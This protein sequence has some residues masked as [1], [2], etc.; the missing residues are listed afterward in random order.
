M[1]VFEFAKKLMKN[2]EFLAG[3]I[4]K[5]ERKMLD[6]VGFEYTMKNG[7]IHHVGDDATE[8]YNAMATLVKLQKKYS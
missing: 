6:A 8:F 7:T 5:N 2:E 1:T 3:G 4:A